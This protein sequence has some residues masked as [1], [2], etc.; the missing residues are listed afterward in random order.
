MLKDIEIN[1]TKDAEKLNEVASR[2]NFDIFVHYGDVM[3]DAKSLL[4]LMSLV[5]HKMKLVLP[6]EVNSKVIDRDLKKVHLA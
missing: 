1:S 3:V 6:D 4:G 5:G 2:Y